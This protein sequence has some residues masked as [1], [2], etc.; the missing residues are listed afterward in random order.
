MISHISEEGRGS[1][2]KSPGEY[3]YVFIYQEVVGL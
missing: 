1:G 3:F 2:E